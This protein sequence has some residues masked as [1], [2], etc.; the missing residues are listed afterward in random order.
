[1]REAVAGLS[2]EQLETRYRNWMVRQIVHHLA[3][4]DDGKWAALEGFALEIFEHH[5]PSWRGCTHA[6]RSYSEL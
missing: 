3:G 4:Y 1:M 6:G 2:A 5:L